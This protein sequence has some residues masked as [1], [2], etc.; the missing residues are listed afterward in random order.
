MLFIYFYCYN[1]FFGFYGVQYF[2]DL[3]SNSV[4]D[5]VEQ[6]DPQPLLFKLFFLVLLWGF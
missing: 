4:Y 3:N 5:I 1:I 6:V 2:L